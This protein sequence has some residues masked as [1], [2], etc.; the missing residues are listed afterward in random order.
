MARSRAYQAG[1][2]GA[3]G[4]GT[5][6]TGQDYEAVASGL[7]QGLGTTAGQVLAGMSASQRIISVANG[8]EDARVRGVAC[9]LTDT[10][11]REVI[12]AWV[13]WS[14]S[15]PTQL[16]ARQVRDAVLRR[17]WGEEWRPGLGWA[18]TQFLG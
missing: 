11:A 12:D 1:R 7:L 13:S 6:V 15:Q 8:L 5:V 18:W 2:V 17:A 3:R 14:S 16:D 4:D 9:G 10:E